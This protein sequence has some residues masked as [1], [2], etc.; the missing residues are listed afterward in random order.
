M[1]PGVLAVSRSRKRQGRGFPWAPQKGHDPADALILT[2]P[3]P[4]LTSDL[5]ELTL[6]SGLR[7]LKDDFRALPGVRLHRQSQH[8]AVSQG[9][10]LPT[11]CLTFEGFLSFTLGQTC[12]PSCDLQVKRRENVEFCFVLH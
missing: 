1:S 6:L 8:V 4:L 5:R 12:R 11:P 9:T 2:W 7:L 10:G 3:N